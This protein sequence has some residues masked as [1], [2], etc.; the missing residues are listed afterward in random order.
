[1]NF[2]VNVV[3][4]QSLGN[5][6]FLKQDPSFV[7]YIQKKLINFYIN[8]MNPTEYHCIDCT[9]CRYNPDGIIYS[10]KFDKVDL[11]F[12]VETKTPC[13]KFIPIEY[14]AALNYDTR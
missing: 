8:A 9:A 12:D 3:F 13:K 5:L 14:V 10:C 2:Y 1:M 6:K 7:H 11:N 4:C